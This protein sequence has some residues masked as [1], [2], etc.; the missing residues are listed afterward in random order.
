VLSVTSDTRSHVGAHLPKSKTQ[1]GCQRAFET[2]V[3]ISLCVESPLLDIHTRRKSGSIN[4]YC[5]VLEQI[6]N[7]LAEDILEALTDESDLS[8]VSFDNQVTGV[9]SMPDAA[10]KSSTAPWFETKTSRDAVKSLGVTS[11]SKPRGFTVLSVSPEKWADRRRRISV[12]LT[13]PRV[14]RLEFTPEHLAGVR[15]GRSLH[16][17]HDHDPRVSV[18]PRRRRGFS[19]TPHFH[20]VSQSA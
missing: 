20:I 14:G 1:I 9:D 18:S 4:S 10:I 17:D 7:Q 11:T 13:F 12:P 19:E 6:N 15:E 3:C 16:H 8:L 5:R 2:D